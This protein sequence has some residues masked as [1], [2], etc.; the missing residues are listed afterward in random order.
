MAVK[1]ST[2]HERTVHPSTQISAFEVYGKPRI[3]SGGRKDFPMRDFSQVGGLF[4]L[5]SI[6]AEIE[7]IV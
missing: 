3:T 7:H 5:F 6:C 2:T 1:A 4:F